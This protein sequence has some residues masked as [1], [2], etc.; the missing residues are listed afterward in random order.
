LGFIWND[1]NKLFIVYIQVCPFPSNKLF[2]IK[3]TLHLQ[4]W[5]PPFCSGETRLD[6]ENRFYSRHRATCGLATKYD[7]CGY[8]KWR[9][10]MKPSQILTKLCKEGKIDGPH[11]SYNRV[12][13]YKPW[14]W[15][16][17][18]KL[19]MD[20]VFFAFF[21]TYFSKVRG[22]NEMLFDGK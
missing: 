1:I 15:I 17:F 8:N 12:S 6:L 16:T 10:P 14:I 3:M 2:L 22:T 9:D 21:K 11:F 18:F 19:R 13:N 5:L 20:K 4:A 7:P